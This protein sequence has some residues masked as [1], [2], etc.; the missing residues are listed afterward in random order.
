MQFVAPA[1]LDVLGSCFDE[2]VVAFGDVE[3]IAGLE[4]FLVVGE[5]ERDLPV[6][7]VAPVRA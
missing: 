5:A 1:E 4:H 2:R 7:D 6:E 3:G